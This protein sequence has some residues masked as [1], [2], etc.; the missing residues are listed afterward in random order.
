M[1]KS[2]NNHIGILDEPK[3]MFGKLMSI[4]D[5]LITRYYQLLTTTS[6]KDIEIINTQMKSGELNPKIA[7]ENLAITLVERLHSQKD[8]EFAKEE[9]VR[10]FSQKQNPEQVN[11]LTVPSGETRLDDLLTQTK[12]IGSKKEV[13]RLIKQG[14]ILIDDQKIDEIFY[15]FSPQDGQLLRIGRKRFYKFVTS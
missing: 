13:V 6:P 1:S 8:A 2:L 3:D 12:L 11:E 5:E 15:T 9:F 10:V 7:K 4:P 14:A